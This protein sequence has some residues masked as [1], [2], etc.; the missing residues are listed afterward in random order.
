[1]LYAIILTPGQKLGSAEEQIVMLTRA[2]RE[3]GGTGVALFATSD[4][5]A[6]LDDFTSRGVEAEIIDL[7][8]FDRSNLDRLLA[9]IDRHRIEAVHWNMFH[10]LRNAY[11]WAL[12]ALR[13][14]VRH[15]FTDH[16]SRDSGGS[17]RGPFGRWAVSTLLRRY[18][19]VHCVSDFVRDEQR[20]RWGIHNGE[21]V[22]HFI[23]TE[24]FRPDT[25]SRE[26]M[27][28]RLGYAASDV[29]IAFVGFLIRQKGVD[30]AVDALA[31]LP[32]STRLLVA[33]NGPEEDPLKQRAAERG[34]ADRV[35]FLGLVRETESIFHAG[36][37]F[38]CPSRWAEAAGFVNLEAQACGLPVVAS[39]IGGIPEYVQDGRTGLL[40]TPESADDLR[41][42][43]D[44]LI[45]TP[46]LQ[47]RMSQEARAYAESQFSAERGTR[48]MIE[49]Y[50][51]HIAPGR[52][53]AAR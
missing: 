15:L 5:N 17:N 3:A 8:R 40:F 27:R 18:H 2:L 53:T 49:W 48:D 26:R 20:D 13:P 9:V 10:P 22:L 34:V 24:R 33:G 41:A 51:S 30:L 37:I 28:A 23:N 6:R 31:G 1:M 42:K 7:E 45:S 35:T 11:L 36:D 14:R 44:H 50:R 12:T 29:V 47:Q 39:R 46:G 4:P 52:L 21:T 38:I 19:G 25:A 32:A 43:L 16:I